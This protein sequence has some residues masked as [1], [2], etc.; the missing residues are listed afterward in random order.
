M[1][2]CNLNFDY[3]KEIVK[4]IKCLL[5]VCFRTKMHHELG[6]DCYNARF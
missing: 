1:M 4:K 2:D 6:T 3:L 5:E